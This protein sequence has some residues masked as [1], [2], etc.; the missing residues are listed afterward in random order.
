M[1]F[2]YQGQNIYYRKS[3]KG[4]RTILFIHGFPE[5]GG[6]FDR[7]IAYLSE[8]CQLLV[9]DLPGAGKSPFNDELR[10][11]EDFA[12][13][14][15]ALAQ[16]EQ[17]E[18]I[19]VLGHS[20]GGY[21]ALAIEEL[22]PHFSKTFGFIHSTAFA[23]SEEKKENRRKSI[24]LMENYGSAAFVKKAVPGNFTESFVQNNKKTI[25]DLI[26]NAS[27]FPKEGLQRFYQ[28]MIDR[29]DR[30][31]VLDTHKPILFI[32]GEEDKAAPLNDLLQQVKI[33]QIAD[34]HILPN[35]AHMGMLEAAD[36][37]NKFVSCYRL[38][39]AG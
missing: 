20:M 29:P 15:I 23:D 35:V 6:I 1:F 39:V 10:S 37:V 16:H 25:D 34:I 14:I 36:E 31:S 33:P 11:V 32:I 26:A 3:G 2:E 13:A 21:I 12:K 8:F 9:P 27:T 7:Q 18:N 38:Q 4:S 5:D 24:Q 28:I 30:T 17:L 19:T 22:F